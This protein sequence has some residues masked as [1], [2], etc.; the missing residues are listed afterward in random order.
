MSSRI[1]CLVL[2]A[3]LGLVQMQM[4][5]GHGSIPDVAALQRKLQAQQIENARAKLINDQLTSEITDLKTGLGAVEGKARM[6]L[7]MAKPNEIFVQVQR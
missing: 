7:G 2:A 3:L 5:S 1:V 6:E 4:W